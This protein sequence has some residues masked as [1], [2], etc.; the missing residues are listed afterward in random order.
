[1]SDCQVS[2]T[3][4]SHSAAAR[5]GIENLTK[6]LAVE[7]AANGIRLNCVAPVC[8]CVCAYTHKY[9]VY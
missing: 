6:T 3:I 9:V 4:H 5:S 2:I 1:M 8:V 7:W